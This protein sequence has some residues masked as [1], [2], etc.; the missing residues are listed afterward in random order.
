MRP[1]LCGVTTD[2]TMTVENL[3]NNNTRVISR[4]IKGYPMAVENLKKIPE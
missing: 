1:Y 2:Y 4:V 3:K